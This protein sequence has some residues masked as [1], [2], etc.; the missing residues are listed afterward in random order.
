MKHLYCIVS[1][2]CKLYRL[3]RTFCAVDFIFNF[4]ALIQNGRQALYEKCYD[5]C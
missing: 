4:D 1:S 2:L 5:Q 3:C